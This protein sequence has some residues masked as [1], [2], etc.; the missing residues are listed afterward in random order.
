MSSIT[1]L[2]TIDANDAITWNAE[3]GQLEVGTEKDSKQ[4]LLLTSRPYFSVKDISLSPCGNLLF[5]SGSTGVTI[6]DIPTK[7]G[8]RYKNQK[9][10]QIYCKTRNLNERLFSCEKRLRILH[11]LWHP[12]S[13]EKSQTLVILTNDSRLRFYDAIKCEEVQT[14]NLRLPV[15]TNDDSE[16]ENELCNAISVLNLGENAIC[17]DF[18]PAML[19]KDLEVLWPIYILMGTGDI[20]LIY[21]NDK[22]PSYADHIIGPLVMYPHAEDNYGADA[23]SLI[24]IHSSPPLLA[25]ATPSGSI[26]HCFAFPNSKTLLPTQILHVYEAIEL[27][28]D[29]IENPSNPYNLHPMRLFKDPISDI[30]YFCV[31]ENG[32][33]TVVLPILEM[34]QSECEIL[35]DIE[36]FSEFLVC[37][38]T[39][40]PSETSDS[41]VDQSTPRGLGVK[42]EQ[43]H[44]VLQVLMGN[45]E[46]IVQRISPATTLINRKRFPRPKLNTSRDGNAS[47]IQEEILNASQIDASRANFDEQIQQILKRKTSIPTLKLSEDLEQRDSMNEL[48]D[49]AVF[50]LKNEYLKKF[51]LAAEAISKKLKVLK[52]DLDNQKKEC[53]K[54]MDEKEHLHRSTVD[55]SAKADKA[56]RTQKELL[57]RIDR[58]L[59]AVTSGNQGHNEAE[60]KLKRELAYLYE[61]LRKYR[62]QFDCAASK[63]EN[64]V[65]SIDAS[66]NFNSGD[67]MLSRTQLDRIQDTLSRHSLEIAELKRQVKQEQQQYQVTNTIS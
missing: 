57:S 14:V 3:L 29:L 15:P 51:N 41:P 38:R 27:S 20:M 21:T 6:V 50:T 46:T 39:T 23:C 13:S 17:F 35:E 8:S 19:I 25:I 52:Y 28:K 22:N 54:I 10:N 37:T 45:N 2:V 31:H 53:Q 64:Q 40:T 4:V 34:I 32:V 67:L 43:S 24:V 33:H 65:A 9:D 47:R 58:V 7:Y 1:N 56:C 16:D 11:V 49:R 26:Y 36:S 18:G 42:I 61:R 55:L 59:A 63:Y 44:I 48:I 66:A 12:K 5:L 30:R 60:A 62:D